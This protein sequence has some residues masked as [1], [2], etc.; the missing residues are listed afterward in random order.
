VFRPKFDI[1]ATLPI[2]NKL[3]CSVCWEDFTLG[4]RVRKLNCDHLFHTDCIVPWLGLH[5]TCPICRR[6][7]VLTSI[8]HAHMCKNCIVF[9]ARPMTAW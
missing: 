8:Y 1:N 7:Q 5:G 6:P 9:R 2:E 4:E 3:Q